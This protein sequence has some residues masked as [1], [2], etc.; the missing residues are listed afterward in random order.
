MQGITY[1]VDEDGNKKAVV[2]DLKKHS[3][4]WEDFEDQMV[5]MKRKNQKRFTHDEVKTMLRKSGKL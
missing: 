3:D 4:L 2:I 1:L 5:A